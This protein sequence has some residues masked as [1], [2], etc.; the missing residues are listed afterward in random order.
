MSGSA[1]DGWR[2]CLM[3]RTESRGSKAKVTERHPR[4][5]MNAEAAEGVDALLFTA[6][7]FGCVHWDGAL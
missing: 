6:P 5:L 3:A 2:E 4:S 7:R 1:P